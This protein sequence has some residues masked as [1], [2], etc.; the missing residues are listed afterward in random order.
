MGVSIPALAVALVLTLQSAA[1]QRF[2]SS[3]DVVQVDVSAIDASGRPVADLTAKD[4]EL[5]VDGRPRRITSVQFVSVPSTVAT[6]GK[7]ALAPVHYSTNAD[8]VGGRLIMIVVDRSSIATGRGKAAIDAAS[9]FVSQLHRADR[10]ALASIP[11]GPQVPFTADHS[12][13]QRR[14]QE[15]D[16]TA[17]ASIG[18]RNLGIADAM[19]F[20]RRNDLAMQTVLEREC[21]AIS[22]SAGGRGGGQSDVLLCR[23]EVR[24]EA[25]VI[26]QDARE[27]ARNSIQGL[28][29]LIDS[30]PPS[31]TPKMLVL[32]S[33]G[34]VVDRESAQLAWLDAKAAAAHVTIFSL[35]LESSQLDASQRRPQAQPSADRALQEQGLDMVAH[36]TR[37]D[38]FRIMSNSDFAFQRL[39]LELSGYYL[40]GFEPEERDRGGRPHTITVGVHRSGVTVRSR[41][42]FAIGGAAAAAT[43][44]SQIVATL[45]DPLPATEI[46]IKLAAYSF[47]DPNHEKLRLLVAAEIDR[48]INPDGRMSAGFVVVDFNGKLIAS[49]MDESLQK[50][51]ARD[52]LSQ[53]YFSTVL[54]D[55]GKHTI[56]FVV[57]DDARR[58]GSVELLADARLTVAGPLRVTDLLIVDGTGGV[59]A[60]PLAPVVSGEIRG[61]TLHGYLELFG[62]S[63]ATLN[64]AS[65]TLEIAKTD[66]SPALARVPVQ[67]GTTKE[68]VRCRIAAARVDLAEFPPGDYV[69]RAV[70]AIGLDAVGQVTRPFRIERAASGL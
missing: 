25:G 66:S 2:K 17:M 40:L 10:V 37:G 12:L 21:G 55:P 53:R 52:G 60:S 14:V 15:I 56:K 6:A 43:P 31:Q 70:I 69:A 42:Q 61:K 16:G 36:A 49:Q 23:N 29:A 62:D 27:R 65:V 32:I 3:V 47:R 44:E 64:D 30:L 45:R 54:A 57:V 11:H 67:L 13:V 34:L 39:A 50:T 20:E 7:P 19:A 26:A 8:E 41:R 33:E 59:E 5:R 35:H 4:F 51:G 9:R 58:R 1:P 48:S 68:S 63:V 24:S 46:P 22:V 18:V 38:L 28:R